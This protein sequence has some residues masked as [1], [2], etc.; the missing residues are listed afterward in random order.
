MSPSMELSRALRAFSPADAADRAP[1]G[2]YCDP[3]AQQGTHAQ[4]DTADLLLL[5]AN[6]LL[7]TAAAVCRCCSIR[8]AMVEFLTN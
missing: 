2:R 3:G 5:A 7:R 8:Q 1:V 4:A 6:L